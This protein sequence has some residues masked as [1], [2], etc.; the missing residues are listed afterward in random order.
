MRFTRPLDYVLGTPNKVAALRA[1]ATLS[2]SPTGLELAQRLHRAVG[3]LTRALHELADE[4]VV[5]ERPVG[6]AITYALNEHHPLVRELLLPLFRG[7]AQLFERV[8]GPQI[9]ELQ[10]ALGPHLLSVWLYGSQARHEDHP[11]SDSDLLVIVDADEAALR[12]SALRA[13]REAMELGRPDRVETLILTLARLREWA[14]MHHPLLEN[15]L[16]DGYAL[17]GEPLQVLLDPT[18]TAGA[19]V[20]DSGER[21]TDTPTGKPP[22]SLIG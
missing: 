8:V 20:G 5:L 11:G 14:D 6:A 10:E 9:R 13:P 15:A 19:S 12:A 16:R 2:Y 18:L 4:G 7:E 17:V 21:T 3:A 1:L 22:F